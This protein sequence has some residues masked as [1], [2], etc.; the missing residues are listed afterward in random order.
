MPFLIPLILGASGTG[1][2]WW[3]TNQKEEEQ[4]DLRKDL[5]AA[6]KIILIILLVLLFLRWLYKKGTIENETIHETV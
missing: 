5:L 2:L 3:K 6:L 4:P 1:F